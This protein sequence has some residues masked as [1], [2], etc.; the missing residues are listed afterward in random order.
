MNEGTGCFKG[1]FKEQRL[2]PLFRKGMP[3]KVGHF[4][5]EA[6]SSPTGQQN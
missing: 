5:Y 6:S 2:I 4:R 1:E 3:K